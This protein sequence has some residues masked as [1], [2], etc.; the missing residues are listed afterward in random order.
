ME[1]EKNI[2]RKESSVPLYERKS[3]LMCGHGKNPEEYTKSL[4]TD[5]SNLKRE[6]PFRKV[7][8]V[9]LKMFKTF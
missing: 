8:K 5:S 3:I 6:L 7:W 9:L 4:Y 2:L 1:A